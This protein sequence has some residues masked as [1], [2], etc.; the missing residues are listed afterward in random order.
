MSRGVG[1]LH[2]CSPPEWKE[3]VIS[4]DAMLVRPWMTYTDFADAYIFSENIYLQIISLLD[5]T[6]TNNLVSIWPHLGQLLSLFHY[7]T[8]VM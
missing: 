2:C 3:A 4:Y 5:I 7:S 8:L 1:K 6:R